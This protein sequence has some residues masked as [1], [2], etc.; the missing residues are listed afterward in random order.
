MITE[1]VS[2]AQIAVVQDPPPVAIV[3]RCD[4]AAVVWYE[5]SCLQ[6]V[7]MVIDGVEAIGMVTTGATVGSPEL[8]LPTAVVGVVVLPR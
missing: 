6:I 1:P 4:V 8:R 2:S 3:T 7:V 5:A